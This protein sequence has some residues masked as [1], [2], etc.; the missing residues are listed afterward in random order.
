MGL[1][2]SDKDGTAKCAFYH[3]RLSE[4]ARKINRNRRPEN[5][6]GI[7]CVSY[8]NKFKKINPTDL[9]RR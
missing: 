8:R 3:N 9:T 2:V 7:P 5:R 1:V 6:V 4:Y